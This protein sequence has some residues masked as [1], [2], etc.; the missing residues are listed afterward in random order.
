[1]SYLGSAQRFYTAAQR[2]ES[3]LKTWGFV[4]TCKLCRE[5]SQE[6]EVAR[7]ELTCLQETMAK[8][9]NQ[10]PNGIRWTWLAELQRRVVD[11]V[12]HLAA[13]GQL[14]PRELCSLA[15]LAHLA[16]Q[17]NLLDETLRVWRQE[18]EEG[19]VLSKDG[20]LFRETKEAVDRWKG[21]RE[22]CVKPGYP[23]IQQ[24]PWLL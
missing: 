6:E 7:G 1:V 16:R 2:Q 14:L 15:H 20:N 3:L 18:M 23:E 11:I 22:A 9:C 5:K 17:Q 13:S 19:Q 12:R 24:F 10:D 21:A 4:C 8:E